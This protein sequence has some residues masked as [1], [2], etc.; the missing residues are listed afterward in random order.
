M[1]IASR[2]A[3]VIATLVSPDNNQRMRLFVS[4]VFWRLF[5]LFFTRTIELYKVSLGNGRWVHSIQRIT[6]SYTMKAGSYNGFPVTR[7]HINLIHLIWLQSLPYAPFWPPLLLSSM[8]MQVA[9]PA[10]MS[11]RSG[12]RTHIISMRPSTGCVRNW[13]S[14]PP[15]WT[16]PMV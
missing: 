5:C 14:R 12:R 9:P 7:K 16:A 13:V 1:E 2:V 11:R 15:R 10:R 3:G 6:R 4:I 8:E